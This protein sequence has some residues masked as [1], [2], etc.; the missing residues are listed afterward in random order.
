MRR[1]SH[2]AAIAALL[3]A[4]PAAR[5][6]AP[7]S[8]PCDAA[9]LFAAMRAAAGGAHWNAV[10]ELTAVGAVTSAGL[11]G[12]AQLR[13]DLGRGRYAER[14]TLPVAGSN[15]EVFDGTTVWSQDI[16]GGV[17]ANDSWYPRARAVTRAYLVRRAYLAPAGR[18]AVQCMPSPKGSDA[19]VVRVTPPGG[20]PAVLTIDPRTHFLQSVAMRTPISTDLTTYGDYREDGGLVLPFSIESGTAFEPADGWTLNVTQYAASVHA[21]ASDFAKPVAVNDAIVLHGARSATVPA[22]LEGRQLLV[23]A[24]IDGHSP[25]PFILDSGGHAIVDTV[26]AKLL[27]LRGSGAGVSGGAGSGTIGLQYTRVRSVRIGNAELRDQPFLVIPYP[28]GFYER[29]TKMPLAG[30]LGLEW[31]ERYAIAIDYA[32]PSVTLTPLGR[33]APPAG[34]TAVALRFQEDMPLAHAA[35]DGHAGRFGVDTGNAGTLIL[36]GDFLRRTGLQAKYARG[37]TVHGEGTGGANTGSLQTLRSFAIGGHELRRIDA[38]FTRMATG[39][40][41]SWTEAGDLGLTVLSRFT[42]VFD[43]ADE[44][45]YL[46]PAV[47][48]LV[49]PPNRSGLQ[50]SK[51]AP[52]AITVVAVKRG[53]AAADA[54]IAAR[55]AILAVNGVPAARISRADFYAMV[56]GAPG[57]RLRLI[58]RHGTFTR[59]VTLV[60]RSE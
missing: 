19:R 39:S 36:Y 46:K 14:F 47:R 48:P 54:G 51:D 22:V 18:G 13:Y 49:L 6:A 28:Y 42:P 2:C 7:P 17:H 4:L 27:G 52:G 15:A 8:P 59:S 1:F 5:P 23:W 26:A 24:S 60:L 57:T 12:T 43:Y 37:T 55:D 29:G 11:L 35:A 58:L 32:K 53:S 31:F 30:I 44:T 33:F 3:F 16:S 9:A 50:F 21:T 40:F 10:R 25:M 34:A 20:I 56:T 41:S 45:L 38:D